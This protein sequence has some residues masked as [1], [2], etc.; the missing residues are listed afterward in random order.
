MSSF[1]DIVQGINFTRSSPS[2]D[3][4]ATV[5]E[6]M[7]KEDKPVMEVGGFTF[8]SMGCVIDG[9]EK[10]E[11]NIVYS[12]KE[13]AIIKW[14]KE[15]DY[16]VYLTSDVGIDVEWTN[17]KGNLRSVN[18]L[19]N[20][21]IRGNVTPT[22]TYLYIKGHTEITGRLVVESGSIIIESMDGRMNDLSIYPKEVSGDELQPL[23][24]PTTHDGMS[25][26]RW[27]P[28]E[29]SV[30]LKNITV[31]D[32]IVKIQTDEPFTIGSYGYEKVPTVTVKGNGD[33]LCPERTGTRLLL[34]RPVAPQGSTKISGRC[35][36]CISYKPDYS[37]VPLTDY[38]QECKDEI[39]QLNPKWAEKV[40]PFVPEGNLTIAID[41]LKF[42][43]DLDISLLFC[44]TDYS[45]APTIVKGACILGVPS[46]LVRFDEFYWYLN[47][48]TWLLRKAGYTDTEIANMKG[49]S[50][51]IAEYARTIYDMP[52][53][54]MNPIAIRTI[55]EM[56]PEYEFSFAGKD[57][58]QC[59]E[60]FLAI[61]L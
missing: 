40:T 29:S 19:N 2:V 53:E 28:V 17:L 57:Y 21:K 37:D 20:T 3:D 59:A 45:T 30:V 1:M 18:S 52:V 22:G 38:A 41:L 26:G 27:S 32:V 5:V 31:S 48:C 49:Y 14:E 61:G 60:E 25:Y 9:L 42:A 15:E 56:I 13:G 54:D 7:N 55:Y 39:M 36:Y 16:F 46:E 43:S 12:N 33:L 6:T 44:P 8:R 58:A 34:K 10:G 35:R 23:I 50:K 47:K 51:A 24:G 4:C 11:G